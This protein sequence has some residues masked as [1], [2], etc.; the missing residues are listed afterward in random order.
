[1]SPSYKNFIYHGLS[2][3][4]V[5]KNGNIKLLDEGIEI[6]NAIDKRKII[7]DLTGNLAYES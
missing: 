1:M 6:E 7:R 3:Q 2:A 4:K 5:N